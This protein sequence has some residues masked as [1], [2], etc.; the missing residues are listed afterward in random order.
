MSAPTIS[1]RLLHP[2]P[3]T[4]E[5]VGGDGKDGEEY[6]YALATVVQAMLKFA[7]HGYGVWFFFTG[8]DR[9]QRSPCSRLGFHFAKVNLYHWSRTVWKVSTVGV[10]SHTTLAIAF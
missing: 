7:I 9:M 3:R 8:M 2:F 5:E 4:D 6:M 10:I 1:L